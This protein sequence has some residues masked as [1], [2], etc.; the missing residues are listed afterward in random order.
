M[1]FSPEL[2]QT[3]CHREKRKQLSAKEK[4]SI[5]QSA[6]EQPA[7]DYGEHTD[8]DRGYPSREPVED[9]AALNWDK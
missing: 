8:R 1:R 5:A 4:G 6:Y 9:D 3:S 7:L 2:A